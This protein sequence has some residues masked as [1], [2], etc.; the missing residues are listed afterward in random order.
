MT[1]SGWTPLHQAAHHGH[2]QVVVTLLEA[3]S[4]QSRR[5]KF[6]ASALGMACAGGHLAC[7]KLLLRSGHPVEDPAPAQHK[8]QCCHKLCE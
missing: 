3:K 8:V 6:G 2:G 1:S 4:D 5:N 7:V